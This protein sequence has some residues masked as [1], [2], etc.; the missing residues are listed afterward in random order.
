[1]NRITPLHVRSAYSLLDGTAMPPRLVQAARALGHERLALTDRN[2]L[3]AAPIFHRESVE[4]GLAP[5]VGAELAW[6]DRQ[7]VALV[8]SDAGYRHLCQLISAIQAD[9]ITDNSA[10]RIDEL[11]ALSEG[12]HYILDDPELARELLRAGCRPSRLWFGIDPESETTAHLGR[13]ARAARELGLPLAA[14]GKTLLIDEGDREVWRLLASMRLGTTFASVLA[15]QLGSAKA[16]L[17]SAQQ[18]DASLRD[19]PTAARNN[20]RLVADCAAFSLLPRPPVFP[21]FE[22]PPELSTREYLRQLCRDGLRWRYGPRPSKAAQ[23]RLERELRIIEKLGFSEYFLVVWDIV[24]YARRQRA[25]IAGRGSGASSI[26]AYALGITNVCPVRHGIPFERFLHERREDFPDLDIDFCWRIRDDVIDYAFRRWGRENV[27]MVCTHN[28]FKTQSAL[29]E[30]LKAFG[31]SNQQISQWRED[32]LPDDKRLDR[33]AALSRRLVGLPH[34]ISVHPGGIVIGRLPINRYAPVQTAAKGVRIT[35]YDKNGVEDIGLVKIDLLGNRNLSTIRDAVDRLRRGRRLE[36]DIEALPPTDPETIAVLRAGKTI[37]CNQLESPAMR[38]LLKMT[39]PDS[40]RD[41]MKVLALIRPGAASIGMK[42]AFIRRLRGIDPVPDGYP[43][44]DK[45]LRPS[46]GVMLYEDDVMLTAAA[47]LGD[48]IVEGDRFRR[49]VQKCRDDEQ[50][51]ELTRTFLGRCRENGVDLAYAKNLW[52]QMAKFNAYSFC[53]AHAA[54]YGLLSY[55]GAYLKAHYPLEFW[56]AALNNNQSMYHTRVYVEEAK[57]QGIR[58]LLPDVNRSGVE[59]TIEDDAVRVGLS[60]IRGL[61]PALVKRLRRAGSDKPFHDLADC[62]RRARPG[63]EELRA[64]VLAGA[65]DFL[66]RNRPTLM[67]ELNAMLTAAPRDL[68]PDDLLLDLGPS[69]PVAPRDYSCERKYFEERRVLGFSVRQHIMALFRP[70]LRREVDADSRAL[71]GRVG[72]RIR[73]A[74][75]QEAQRTA[76]TKTGG[77]VT[78][79]TI[80]DEYGLVEVNVFPAGARGRSRGAAQDQKEGSRMQTFESYGP[81]IVIGKVEDQYGSLSVTAED[82][83]KFQ[84]A[85]PG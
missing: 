39:Q 55:A 25:P 13:L 29:R 52:V 46:H 16:C 59:F 41:I 1:M 5:I 62:W 63:S 58:F 14:T 47:L 21:G 57:R 7:L 43:P 9:A 73:F 31:Y 32:S 78:F 23:A 64:L 44:V 37:G 80:E 85:Q 61:G 65:F 75:V 49:A 74:G 51:Q 76:K 18:L 34:N 6:A 4:S 35:Q 3:Y 19:W 10:D 27:A 15:E 24:Q 72:R 36:L 40:S 83:R 42:D 48:D 82:V 67:F 26:V 60:R 54:S 68:A 28:C 12:L 50:R 70:Q 77:Y 22:C 81:Y 2:N 30:S 53:R 8:H 69:L 45:I 84:F 71:P 56:V 38:H 11:T 20:E 66:R 33:I 17:R 79:L